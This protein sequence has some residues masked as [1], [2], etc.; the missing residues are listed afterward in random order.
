MADT[1]LQD[2]IF[3]SLESA[4][5]AYRRFA[6]SRFNAAGVDITIDQGMV[7]K[8]I[9]DSPDITLQQVGVV[10]FKDF[11]SVTRIVQLLEQKGLLRRKPHPTD[12]RRSKLLLTSAGEAAIRRSTSIA[13][14]NRRHA[15]KGV[16]AEEV[17]QLR[18]LLNRITENCETVE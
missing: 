17:E 14:A 13:Q 10:V 5:K 3:Y 8:T 16:S 9:H 15:L 11:A 6:Q 4:I 12:K 1:R 18:A 7:L 2:V